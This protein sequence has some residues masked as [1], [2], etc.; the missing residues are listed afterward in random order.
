MEAFLI[1]MRDPD[2]DEEDEMPSRAPPPRR[3]DQDVALQLHSEINNMRYKPKP[4]DYSHGPGARVGRMRQ[5]QKNESR[6]AEMERRI[7]DRRAH[8]EQQNRLR[9]AVQKANAKQA[10]DEVKYMLTKNDPSKPPSAAK[11]Q[12]RAAAKTERKE[13]RAIAQQRRATVKTEP[14]RAPKPKT[15]AKGAAGGKPKPKKS[16]KKEPA[17]KPKPK[18]KKESAKPRES[19]KTKAKG[20]AK[21]KPKG[22]E[23]IFA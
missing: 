15:K 7:A 5:R 13:D 6:K 22:D 20:K 14:K 1:S 11:R 2:S 9:L 18:I 21:A 19:A 4:A 12:K 17:S 23:S 10:S 3:T 16:K 8:I